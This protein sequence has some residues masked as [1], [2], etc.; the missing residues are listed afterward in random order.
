MEHSGVAGRDEH[1]EHTRDL[2]NSAQEE[3]NRESSMRQARHDNELMLVY[4]R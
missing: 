2:D 4:S 3:E 1:V